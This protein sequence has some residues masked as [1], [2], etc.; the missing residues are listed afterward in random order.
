M[1]TGFGLGSFGLYSELGSI[2][3]GHYSFQIISAPPVG[4]H[5]YN[6]FSYLLICGY[7]YYTCDLIML[8]DFLTSTM[9]FRQLMVRIDLFF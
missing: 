6:K 9:K 3:G 8:S 5:L 2:Y 7:I 1:S 4:W